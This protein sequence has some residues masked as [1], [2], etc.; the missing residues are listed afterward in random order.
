MMHNDA[1]RTGNTV[2]LRGASLW[3]AAA[4]ILA[5]SLVGLAFHIPLLGDIFSGKFHRVLQAH[6]DFLLMS[7]LILGFYGA[8]VPLPWHVRWAMV[9]GAF[10]NSSLFLFM[11]IFPTL[12]PS[13]DHPPAQGFLPSL[14]LVYQFAS[15]I[16]TTYGFG[17]GAWTI[18]RSTIGRFDAVR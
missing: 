4:L 3:I 6:I 10:T 11:A 1:N 9:V 17:R 14:F 13:G 7:A 5:W 15:L 2:L 18:M 12:D 8:R 16:T